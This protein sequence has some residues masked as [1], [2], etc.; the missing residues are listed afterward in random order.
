MYYIYNSIIFTVV[1]VFLYRY[2]KACKRVTSI[3]SVDK[4]FTQ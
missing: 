4:I 2:I 3:R 1:L